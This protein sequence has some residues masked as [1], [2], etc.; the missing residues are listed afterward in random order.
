[1]VSRN[2]VALALIGAGADLLLQRISTAR[3]EEIER[4]VNEILRLFDLVDENPL[5]F[6][7]LQRR[8]DSLET[9]VRES[10]DIAASRRC[11]VPK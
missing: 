5:L 3:A 11:R 6:P 7:V 4:R 9:L 2:D 10:A 1:M 8:L